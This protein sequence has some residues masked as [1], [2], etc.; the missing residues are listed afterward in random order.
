MKDIYEKLWD[1]PRFRVE[2]NRSNLHLDI[3][4]GLISEVIPHASVIDWGCGKGA[5][6]ALL[7]DRGYSVVGCNDI[8]GNSLDEEMKTRFPFFEA[9][10][11]HLASPQKATLSFCVDVMEH[12]PEEEIIPALINISKYTTKF[13]F[14]AID[15]FEDEWNG[16]NLHETIRPPEY[17]FELLLNHFGRASFLYTLPTRPTIGGLWTS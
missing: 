2:K 10:P 5:K 7:E 17:W 15:C 16:Y 13:A 4:T 14:F 3:F 11:L 9:Q 8:A 6:T 12:L 1:T